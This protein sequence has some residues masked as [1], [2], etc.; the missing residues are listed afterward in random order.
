MPWL[1]LFLLPVASS[2]I[3]QALALALALAY[4]EAGYN[5][6]LAARRTE[7]IKS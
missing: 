1:N 6:A 5:L 4:Y 3:G 7:E 2:G